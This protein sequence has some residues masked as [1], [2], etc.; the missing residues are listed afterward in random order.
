MTSARHGFLSIIDP[1]DKIYYRHA[2]VYVYM[3]ALVPTVDE[4][5][6]VFIV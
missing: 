2:Y 1:G 3:W 5:R 6:D 4:I